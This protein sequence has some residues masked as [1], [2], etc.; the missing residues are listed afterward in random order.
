MKIGEKNTQI[1]QLQKENQELNTKQARLLLENA[2][3]AE[4]SKANHE[5]SQLKRKLSNQ[6]QQ[7]HPNCHAQP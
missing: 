5:L 1:S 7:R 6:Q 2:K 3:V 4:L